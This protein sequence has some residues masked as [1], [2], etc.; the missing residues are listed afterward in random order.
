MRG[1]GDMSLDRW[2]DSNSMLPRNFSGSIKR[3]S[4]EGE[5]QRESITNTPK[6]LK[7]NYMSI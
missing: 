2:T 3:L 4:V 7:N 6:N 1:L 5:N